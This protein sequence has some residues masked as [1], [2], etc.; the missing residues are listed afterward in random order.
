MRQ[1]IFPRWLSYHMASVPPVGKMLRLTAAAIF[2]GLTGLAAAQAQTQEG[3]AAPAPN[4]APEASEDRSEGPPDA[5]E[6]ISGGRDL[7]AEDWRAL[8][9]GRTVWYLIDGAVW[10][11]ESYRGA[12]GEVTFQFP[13][14]ECLPATW[15]WQAPWFCF[16][17][18]SA[19]NGA[20]PHCFRH[21]R[22]QGQLWAVSR[23]GAPQA[24]ERID[25][26]PIVCGKT[27]VS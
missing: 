25:Q 3:P 15:T 21:I 27:P 13:D 9:D 1:M 23:G 26:S 6:I 12:P 24:I 7:S 16:D 18:G 14:G 11:R 4:P 17:F 8:T 22:Y 5:I 19:L 10:G 20:A 2:A